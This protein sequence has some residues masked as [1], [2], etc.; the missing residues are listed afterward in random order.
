MT[1]LTQMKENF[2]YFKSR[3]KSSHSKTNLDI[4][5]QWKKISMLKRTFLCMQYFIFYKIVLYNYNYL[6]IIAEF[7]K[8]TETNYY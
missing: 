7:C 5:N 1:L 3:G 8:T 2:F 4:K 6:L